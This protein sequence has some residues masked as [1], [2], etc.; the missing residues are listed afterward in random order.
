MRA[1]VAAVLFGLT[2]TAGL[3]QSAYA[4]G[5]MMMGVGKAAAVG[6]CSYT[7]P[8][9]VVAGPTILYSTRAASTAT[10]GNK[11]MNV[12]NVSDVACGDLSSSAS[13]GKM[14]IS[15][16]GGSNCS[17]VTCTIKTWYDLSG[18]ANDT[19]QSTIA[20]RATF[21]VS[22]Q[23][24]QPCATCAGS[25]IYASGSAISTTQ[26]FTMISYAERTGA[27]T[28]LNSIAR[29][30][31]TTIILE[32][33]TSANQ[34]G[35]T[36]GTLATATASDNAF[37][38]INAVANGASS[39]LSIDGAT[40]TVSANTNAMSAKVFCVGTGNNACTSA[41]SGLNGNLTEV[42][43][44]GSTGFTTSNLTS[45]N[46]NQATFWGTTFAGAGDVV[47]G[48]TAFW[49]A[50][51][52]Y[53]GATRGL[54]VANVC[55]VADA[56]CADISSDISS[57]VVAAPTIG[58]SACSVVTC[59]IKVMYDQTLGGFDAT[60][61]T[62]ATRATLTVASLGS[63][64]IYASGSGSQFYPLTAATTVVEPWTFISFSKRSGN[65][66]GFGGVLSDINS[67]THLYYR[68]I[69]D[70]VGFDV[71]GTAIT[72]S[73]AV[74]D[75]SY[76][77]LI[78]VSASVGSNSLLVVDGSATTGTTGTSS[79]SGGFCLFS[80]SNGSVCGTIASTANIGELAVYPIG[81]NSTQY[82][83]MNTNEAA[84]Y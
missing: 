58:G 39:L 66:T 69:V 70:S 82:G 27:T 55:N 54:K 64:A 57:G 44:W 25:C 59:T 53:A 83:N 47:S 21:T 8:V 51:R 28:S 74:P 77:S 48:A 17:I 33:T 67:G 2:L 31:T 11:L 40:A 23:N 72:I 26:P 14:V 16:I 60:Q 42:G 84:F 6:G 52:A 79:L 56:A 19:T 68:S 29:S 46:T 4:V 36:A 35:I 18:N 63:A 76:H 50:S 5:E 73:G 20:S 80:T 10:C 9:D 34:A 12:C 61:A 75:A 38:S 24:S 15:T 1:L 65:F 37:H 78:G 13:T 32:F 43:I 49:S 81:F 30:V 3:H 71:N 62:I 22:C 41:A 45:M 7:G